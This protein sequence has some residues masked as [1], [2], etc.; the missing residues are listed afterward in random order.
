MDAIA[1]GCLTAL[2]VART[3]FS[4]PGLGALAGGGAALV[5]FSLGF[6]RLAYRWGLSS[7]GLDMTVL[8]LGTCAF[9][10]ASAQSE[11]R[12][13][14]ILSPLLKIGQ[15]SYEIYLTHMFVVFAAFSLFVSAGQPMHQVPVLFGVVILLSG[16]LGWLV[17]SVYS[18][19]MNRRLRQG[20]AVMEP[21]R[22]GVM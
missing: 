22:S 4:R 12:S 8:A 1:L 7:R 9:I 2:L 14:R 11:W 20:S 19:P 17:A 10:A 16:V 6:S 21:A 18:E 3:R 5:I 15:Y 13:P